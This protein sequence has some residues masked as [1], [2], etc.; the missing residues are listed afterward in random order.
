MPPADHETTRPGREN[1]MAHD[2]CWIELTTEQPDAAKS[3][4]AELFGW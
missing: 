4:Y 2:F 3:F 1:T